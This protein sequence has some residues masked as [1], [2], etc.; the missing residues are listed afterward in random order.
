MAGPSAS[1]KS[2]FATG[3]IERLVHKSYQVCILDPEGDYSTLDDIVTLGSRLRAP[4]IS[5]VLDVLQD[6]SVNVVVNLLG[7]E[8]DDRP[9]YFAELLPRLLAMRA[10]TGRPHWLVVTRSITSGR[11]PMGSRRSASRRSSARRCSSP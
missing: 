8:L 5:E 6:P 9:A 11:R 7:V 1:G 2:T 4:L 10:R 3:L